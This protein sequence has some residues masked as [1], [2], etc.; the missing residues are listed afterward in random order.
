[1]PRWLALIASSLVWIVGVPLA[2]AGIPW[3]IA[4]FGARHGWVGGAPGAWNLLGAAPMAAGAAWLLW[5]MPLHLGR[6][7][8]R[9]K[10][11]W[12]PGYLLERGPYAWS[13]NPMYVGELLLWL[14]QAILYGSL[15][16]LA[17]GALLA[18]AMRFGAIPREERALEARFG[19]RY[20]DY[21]RRVPRWLGARRS[22]VSGR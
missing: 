16:V 17:G 14:G 4:S 15:G 2:H 21:A 12:T 1:M 9:V 13:R 7:P 6:T 8:A 3:L 11:E 5:V 18:L 10:L 20:R 22:G 19:E